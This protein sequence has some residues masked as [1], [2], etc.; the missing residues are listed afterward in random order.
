[1]F[2]SV[3]LSCSNVGKRAMA[4][5]DMHCSQLAIVTCWCW[6]EKGFGF[7]SEMKMKNELLFIFV[8]SHRTYAKAL[9]RCPP[10][11]ITCHHLSLAVRNGALSSVGRKKSFWLLFLSLSLVYP[12]AALFWIVLSSHCALCLPCVIPIGI[13]NIHPK[14]LAEIS[15]RGYQN[16]FVM[17]VAENEALLCKR[18]K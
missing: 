1:M 17:S 4:R 7:G 13:P 11:S 3:S 5:K 12:R 16:S 2:D 15:T 18:D 8:S 10:H 9:R 14:Y 6:N